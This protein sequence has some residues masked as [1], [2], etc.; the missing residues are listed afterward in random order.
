[1]NDATARLVIGSKWR[2]K[3]TGGIYK[4]RGF[5]TIESIWA[6]AVVYRKAA[7]YCKPG[8]PYDQIDIVRPTAEFL[9][10]RFE[11]WE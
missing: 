6:P 10:G 1:M 8:A 5:V 2:H 4:V 11:P 7:E 9:D 3:K